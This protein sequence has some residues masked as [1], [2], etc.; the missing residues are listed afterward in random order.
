MAGTYNGSSVE[1]PGTTAV[2]S[3][4]P[5]GSRMAAAILS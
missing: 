1:F 2:A 5:S 4:V 3:G